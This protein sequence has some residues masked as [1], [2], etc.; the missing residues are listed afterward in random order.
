ME[1][2]TTQWVVIGCAGLTGLVAI[3]VPNLDQRDPTPMQVSAAFVDR[4][5]LAPRPARAAFERPPGFEPVRPAGM[6]FDPMPIGETAGTRQDVPDRTE[7]VIALGQQARSL[8]GDRLAAGFAAAAPDYAASFPESKDRD[9]IELRMLNR[10]DAALIA[11][12]LSPRERAAGV[13]ETPLGLELWALAVAPDFPAD[14]LTSTVVRQVLTGEI[15]N[16]QRLGHDRGPAVVVVPSGRDQT[17]RAARSL[18]LGDAFA[19]EAIRVADDRH[20]RDQLLRHEGA[21]AVVRVPSTAP[22]GMK[23]LQIDWNPPTPEAFAYGNY[24]YGVP[25]ALVTSA[26]VDGGVQAFLDYVRSEDGREAFGNHVLLPVR[27]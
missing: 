25:L 13:R 27:R 9:A 2:N 23:L 19:P 3:V 7:L 16:W 5:D 4:Y 11:G 24:P 15:K 1:N 20:V 6:R 14:S 18:I 10:V 8:C 12:K 17:R 26:R 22:V 21:I